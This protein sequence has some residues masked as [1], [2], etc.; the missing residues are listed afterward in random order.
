[1]N[2]SQTPEPSLK[3]LL[4]HFKWTIDRFEEILKNEKSDYYRD[5][6][7]QRFSFTCDMALKC[8]RSMA[9]EQGKSCETFRQCVEWC[10]EKNWLEENSPW[11]EITE[12]HGQAPKKLKGESADLE[13]DKLDS[14]CRLLKNIY[15]HLKI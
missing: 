2:T 14:Y 6:A 12:S 5:A 15:Q 10:L 1:M 8:I 7:L 13:Y 9:A 4:T 3:I 11:K